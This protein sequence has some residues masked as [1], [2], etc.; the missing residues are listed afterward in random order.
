MYAGATKD[1]GGGVETGSEGWKKERMSPLRWRMV[2]PVEVKEGEGERE[3][4]TAERS[5]PDGVSSS[6]RESVDA[7]D[8][9]V[10]AKR[11]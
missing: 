2:C 1:C 6:E 7:G 10:E 5:I 9:G 4:V 8:G 11:R 3:V